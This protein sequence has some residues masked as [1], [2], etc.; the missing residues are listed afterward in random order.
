MFRLP[1]RRGSKEDA[2]HLQYLQRD[3][4][5]PSGPGPGLKGVSQRLRVHV[6]PLELQEHGVPAPPAEPSL[7]LFFEVLSLL[8]LLRGADRD[9]HD[10]HEL[11]A[12][13]LHPA[14]AGGDPQSQ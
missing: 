5:Q 2:F 7:L 12:D 11:E 1:Q 9:P 6:P 3:A 10:F 14:A 8:P 13:R 4:L